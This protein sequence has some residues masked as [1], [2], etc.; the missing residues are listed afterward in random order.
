MWL[1]G[2]LQ[3]LGIFFL[4]RRRTLEGLPS[5]RGPKYQL[6]DSTW[7]N[8]GLVDAQDIMSQLCSIGLRSMERVGQSIATVPWSCKNCSDTSYSREVSHCLAVE[9]TQSQLH[10][11]MVSQGVWGSY[12]GTCCRCRSAFPCKEMPPI[13]DPRC[14]SWCFLENA[15]FNIMLYF[16]FPLL[17]ILLIS[18][19]S[20]CQYNWIL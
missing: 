5:R 8:V 2:C 6:L 11:H 15:K 12:L 9:G 20:Y 16:S 18:I 10:Q 3:C 1:F 4:M 14:Q 19:L 7:S 13:T 17:C